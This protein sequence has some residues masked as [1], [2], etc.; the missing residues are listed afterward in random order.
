MP[1][2]AE[3]ERLVKE[4]NELHMQLIKYKEMVESS[5]MSWKSQCRQSQNEVQDLRFLLT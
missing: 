2:V 3:N 5:E 1:L 4:N